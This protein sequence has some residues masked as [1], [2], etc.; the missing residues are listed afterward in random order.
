[1]LDYLLDVSSYIFIGSFIC[2]LF[3]LFYEINLKLKGRSVS[4]LQR[5][6]TLILG[7]YFSILFALTI[8]PVYGFSNE[9]VFDEVNLTP[10]KVIE[11]IDTNYLN[12]FG[13]IAMFM[14]LGFFVPMISRKFHKMSKVCFLGFC[15]SFMIEVIQLFLIRGTDIDDLILNT[16]GTVIG[17]AI[18]L[19]FKNGFKVL[20]KYI[21]IRRKR[22]EKILKR[23]SA[24]IFL[25]IG[26]MLFSVMSI[27][28]YK[29][30]EYMQQETISNENI[31]NEDYESRKYAEKTKD[32]RFKSIS[33]NAKNVYIVEDDESKELY[34]LDSNEKIAPASTAKMLTAVTVLQFCD[35]YDQVIV[36]NEI[37]NVASDASKAGLRTGNKVTVKQLLE[38]IYISSL[39]WQKNC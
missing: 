29:R 30:G 1:M 37:N 21:G 31:K 27:G 34:S 25:L 12:F 14:P 3:I 6:N 13:N 32:N 33:F 7:V 26:V 11:N 39:Y 10:G 24:I 23:D 5:M 2:I 36:G 15:I 4:W 9:I 8:S 28:F 22:N 16:I 35:L 19:L 17:Y 38:G 18:F 20:G